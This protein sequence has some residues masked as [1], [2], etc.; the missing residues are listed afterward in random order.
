VKEWSA[1]R[2][3]VHDYSGH[4][5][6]A[7]LSRALAARGHEVTHQYCSSYQTGRGAVDRAP[8]DPDGYA[9]EALSLGTAFAR[10]TP[11]LRIKQE[12]QYG[13][14]AARAIRR[15]DPDVALLSNIPLISLLIVTGLLRRARI[16]FVFWQ[17][18]VYSAAISSAAVARLGRKGRPIGVIAERLERRIARASAA[19]VPIDASF[20]GPLRGWGVPDSRVH[21]IPNWAPIAELPVRR[22]DNAWARRHGISGSPVV[23]YSGTLGLK[24]DPSLLAD[25]ADSLRGVATVVVVSQGLG[26]SVLEEARSER[27][28]DNLLLLDFQPYEELPD[29]MASADVLV[30]LLEPDASKYSVPSKVLSYLCAARPIVAVIPEANSVARVITAADAGVVVRPGDRAGLSDALTGLLGDE[31]ARALLGKGARRYA[32]ETFDVTAISARFEQILE[33]AAR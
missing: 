21:V 18:D 16:P 12:I 32:E 23:L 26:R 25:A 33:Q 6:Q 7:Q 27:R 1:V 22:K 29:V 4:P 15:A 24:H 3:V 2:V 30:A 11:W 10:Y 9:A 5:G 14:M 19:V 8:G 28:L 20:T 13:V 17:Q 31:S